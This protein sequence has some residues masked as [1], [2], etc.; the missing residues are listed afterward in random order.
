MGRDKLPSVHCSNCKEEIPFGE[1]INIPNYYHGKYCKN[2]YD[3]VLKKS[4][5]EPWTKTGL[6]FIDSSD[7]WR[8]SIAEALFKGST[9]YET[10]S[11]G[12]GR[13]CDN[14]KRV[15]LKLI[16]WADIIFIIN[17]CEERHKSLLLKE[18]EVSS[19][20]PILILNVPFDHKK[21][22]FELEKIL[23]DRLSLFL[24]QNQ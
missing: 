2:C 10:K 1:G 21:D 20:K 9:E 22:P 16:G 18:V 24:N 7:L 5:N 8:S 3:K 23:R 15:N 6:L 13:F 14:E 11:A 17:E 4:P 12:V 19:D